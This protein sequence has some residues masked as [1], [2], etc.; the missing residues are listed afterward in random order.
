M[1]THIAQILLGLQA[2]R[3]GTLLC[4]VAACVALAGCVHL[5]ERVDAGDQVLL[6]AAFAS[7]WVQLG[8]ARGSFA[9][10]RVEVAA[11]GPRAGLLRSLTT[12][13]LKK[14]DA[15]IVHGGR[16][17]ITFEVAATV[18]GI[19][20]VRTTGMI[21]SHNARIA[22]ARIHFLARWD[23]SGHALIDTST[24]G[25]ASLTENFFLGIIRTLDAEPEELEAVLRRQLDPG[26]KPERR[27]RREDMKSQWERL[28]KSIR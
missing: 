21:S 9:G 23:S 10:K 3:R 1:N 2:A 15:K 14:M 12:D 28:K 22:T 18:F 20:T 6:G 25:R 17:D 16:T 24:R 4:L 11:S 7:C 8:L 13:G 27:G 19:D 5:R 26:A